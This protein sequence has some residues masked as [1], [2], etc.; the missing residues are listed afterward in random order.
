MEYLPVL[1]ASL[2]DVP[3]GGYSLLEQPTPKRTSALPG[4]YNN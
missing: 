4:P 3:G 2:L 1:Q